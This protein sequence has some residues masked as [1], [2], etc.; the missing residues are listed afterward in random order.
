MEFSRKDFYGASVLLPSRLRRFIQRMKGK[1]D[2]ASIHHRKVRD[3]LRQVA[4]PQ[5]VTR[6][7]SIGNKTP[8]RSAA[9]AAARDT[10]FKDDID[11]RI[12]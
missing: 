2:V 8:H 5:V 3:Q 4:R 9:A 1:E 11:L 10:T 6:R 7:D 12:R